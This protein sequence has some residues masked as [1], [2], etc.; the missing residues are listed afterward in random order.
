M[1][2]G[3]ITRGRRHWYDSRSTIHCKRMSSSW[4]STPMQTYTTFLPTC[5]RFADVLVIALALA[6]PLVAQSVDPALLLKPS[7]D[8]WPTYHGDYS[9]QHHSALTQITPTNVQQ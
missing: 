8:S 3:G 2:R 9:G 4:G 5:R 1:R 7:P 6:T